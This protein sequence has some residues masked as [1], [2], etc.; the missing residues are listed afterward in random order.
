MERTAVG[1]PAR[2]MQGTTPAGPAVHWCVPTVLHMRMH[3]KVLAGHCP[4]SAFCI[5][6]ISSG[7]WFCVAVSAKLVTT[8][9]ASLQGGYVRLHCSILYSPRRHCGFSPRRYLRLHGSILDSSNSLTHQTHDSRF[10]VDDCVV[11]TQGSQALRWWS[12]SLC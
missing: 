11:G 3:V 2:L 10:A 7:D 5:L 4:G 1:L 6:H 12:W 8:V 9:L